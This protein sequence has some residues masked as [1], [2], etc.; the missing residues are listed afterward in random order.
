MHGGAMHMAEQCTVHRTQD[1][2]NNSTT[3]HNP[4]TSASPMQHITRCTPLAW[5][6]SKLTSFAPHNGL[7][8]LLGRDHLD[9]LDAHQISKAARIVVVLVWHVGE[10]LLATANRLELGEADARAVELTDDI[11]SLVRARVLLLV[12]ALGVLGNVVSGPQQREGLALK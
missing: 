11:R 1:R 7:E 4:I 3:T 8:A 2:D 9:G 6:C 5:Q 12:P 10:R